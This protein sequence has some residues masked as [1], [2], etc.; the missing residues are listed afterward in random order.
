MKNVLRRL[1][2]SKA[3]SV[4]D[5]NSLSKYMVLERREN[6]RKNQ[7]PGMDVSLSLII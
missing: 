3:M 1:E 6:F 4:R 2:M 7:A 5:P